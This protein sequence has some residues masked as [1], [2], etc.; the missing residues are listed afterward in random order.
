MRESF[1]PFKKRD[2]FRER[3]RERVREHKVTQG[4]E[5]EGRERGLAR[6]KIKN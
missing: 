1:R 3:E 4:G 6:K 5:E 2:H